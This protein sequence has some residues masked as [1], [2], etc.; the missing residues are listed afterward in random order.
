M[1]S[2]SLDNVWRDDL[3]YYDD[4]QSLFSFPTNQLSLY[5]Q[6]CSASTFDKPG[7][8]LVFGWK[9]R[10]TATNNNI[11]PDGPARAKYSGTD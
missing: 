11:L 2:I 5:K 9:Y 7:E 6:D 1:A 8:L 3:K 4:F 10:K